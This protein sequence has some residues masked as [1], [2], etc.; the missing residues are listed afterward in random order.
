ME[1][2]LIV[3]YLPT[4]RRD[5]NTDLI[6]YHTFRTYEEAAEERKFRLSKPYSNYKDIRI[7][8]INNH[9]IDNHPYYVGDLVD[10]FPFIRDMGCGTLI[11][12]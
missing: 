4:Y 12:E 1:Y 2:H 10:E 8:C 3:Q 9:C 6:V 7:V 11:Y 5:A